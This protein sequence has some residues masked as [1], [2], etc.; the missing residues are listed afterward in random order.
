M[1]YSFIIPVFNSAKYI[2]RCVESILTQNKRKEYEIILVNDGSIDNSKEVIDSLIIKYPEFLRYYEQT[3]KGVSS[4]RNFGVKQS[5]GE[6]IIF[7][8]SDDKIP[9]NFF[10]N[11]NKTVKNENF[12]IIKTKVRCLE[13]KKYDGRFELPIFNSLSGIDALKEFCGSNNIFA[14]PWSYIFKRDFFINNKLKFKINTFHEDLELIPK[15]IVL[16][17]NVS[18]VD[19]YGYEYIKRENSISTKSDDNIELL[20]INDFLSHIY[21]LVQYFIENYKED[22]CVIVNYFYNRTKIKVSNLRYSVKLMMNFETLEEIE[23]TIN[24]NNNDMLYNKL[25]SNYQKSIDMAI[26]FAIKT[27]K[28]NL[29]AVILGGSCGK[30]YP[31]PNISDIDIYIILKKHDYITTLKFYSLISKISIHVGTTFYSISE[32]SNEFIDNKTKIMLYEKEVLK[33]NP[34]LYGYSLFKNVNYSQVVENDTSNLPNILQL[35]RRMIFKVQ[36]NEIEIDKKVI[37][38]LILLLK[39]YLNMNH[40]YADGYESVIKVFLEL[41]NCES[42]CKYEF[43]IINIIGNIR[44]NKVRVIDFSNHVINF[45]IKEMER[46]SMEKRVSSRGIIIEGEYVYA[47]FR[48]RKKEDGTYK[49]YY[50]LPGGGINENETLEENVVREMKEEFSVDVKVEK[51]L[52]RDE[53]EDSIA[54]FFSC[55]IVNGVP[56]LGGEELE[57]CSESNYYE[58]RKIP[59]KDL[60]K[61]DILAKDMILKAYNN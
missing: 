52:G 17:D 29:V 40:I 20:R 6:Y 23:K 12:D 41:Y 43:D 38:T 1:K 10:V 31:I 48:R 3:N 61:I 30:G 45:I 28:K 35:F 9:D 53:S 15:I 32:L 37:K 36:L 22:S 18:S 5:Y 7:V 56:V 57:R 59:I 26:S 42:T 49:E 21:Y 14:T 55:S 19:W 11:L 27:F 47:M 60:D 4:A 34:T 24:K 54:H 39:C 50:V 46:K 58:I 33:V 16:A 25:P 2:E 51:Y 8:D 44:E 13:E